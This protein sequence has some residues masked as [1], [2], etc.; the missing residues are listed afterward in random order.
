MT[1][2]TRGQGVGIDP[3]ESQQTTQVAQVAQVEQDDALNRRIRSTETEL[4]DI[5]RRF[6]REVLFCA[7]IIFI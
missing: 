7:L 3:P 1:I 6:A 2:A 4:E 5:T